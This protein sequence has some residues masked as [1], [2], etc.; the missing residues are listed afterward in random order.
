MTFVVVCGTVLV[1]LPWVTAQFFRLNG[2]RSFRLEFGQ[3]R[4]ARRISEA[5]EYRRLLTH[6]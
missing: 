1:F 5:A 6:D 3:S 4:L 2:G